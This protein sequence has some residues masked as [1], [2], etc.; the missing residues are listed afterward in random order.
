MATVIQMRRGTASEWTAANPLLAQGEIGTELDTHKWK[1][2]DGVLRWA[3]L[4]YVTGGPGP[5]GPKGDPGAAGPAG[6]TGPAG[7]K[8]DTG[9]TGPQGVPGA[10]GGAGP[11]GPQGNAGPVGATGPAGAQGVQGV[12]GD[13][14]DTGATGP[15]GLGV[16]AGGASGQVLAKKSAADN[17]TQ[18]VA[19][20]GGALTQKAARAYRV[21]AL[22]ASAAGS[23]KIPL[24][25]LSYDTDGSM[26][27][28][29]NG[30][31]VARVAGYYVVH[32]SIGWGITTAANFTTF[33][34]IFKNG[35]EVTR[36]TSFSI[37][38]DNINLR[39]QEVADT[40]Y[41]NVGDYIELYGYSQLT[42]SLYAGGSVN[43]WF[44]FASMVLAGG[45]P[46]PAGPAGGNATVPIDKWHVVGAA[47]EPAFQNGWTAVA[48]ETPP[49]FRKDPL[50]VVSLRGTMRGGAANT[51]AFTLPAGYR[52]PVAR[53]RN[54]V[55]DSNNGGAVSGVTGLNV[56]PDGSVLANAINNSDLL[57]V[58][59][60]EI[61]FDTGTVTA[62]PTGP[63][64]PQGPQGIP[65][66]IGNTAA[67]LNRGAAFSVPGGVA[68]KI[69]LNL[70]TYDAGG[71]AQ[72]ANG[73]YVCPAAGYYKVDGSVSGSMGTGGSGP[74]EIYASVYQNGARV[75]TG[76]IVTVPY[77]SGGDIGETVA[78]VVKCNA[79]DYLELYVYQTG[80]PVALYVSPIMNY[81]AVVKVDQA[82]P[83]GDKGDSGGVANLAARAYRGAALTLAAGSY[84]KV[85]ADT[86]SRDSGGHIANG[87]YNVTAAGWYQ[88]NGE[89]LLATGLVGGNI[90]FVAY[91]YLNGASCSAGEQVGQTAGNG[92]VSSVVSDAI[93]CV[94]GDYIE[95][96]AYSS[97][98][99][100]LAVSATSN[101]LSVASVDQAGPKGDKGDP[102]PA[103]SG[104]GGGAAGFTAFAYLAANADLAASTWTTLPVDTVD[105]GH[106][107]GHCMNLAQHAYVCP[108]AGWYDVDAQYGLVGVAQFRRGLDQRMEH[109]LQVERR[110]ADHL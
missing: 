30:R 81:L 25:T 87:R 75:S 66:G 77:A 62:M 82:G 105:A 108:A 8:G 5:Q 90:T 46:G 88:I 83:K 23:T 47:G 104:G 16:P 11:Q 10:A 21:G 94:P 93:Y 96:W 109:G 71:N 101:Y 72:V 37:T 6:A 55:A 69:P 98:A 33:P 97:A 58:S 103:G 28:L 53:A 14:G 24:D 42:Y 50:G 65:G 52:P 79:G 29:A 4:P 68:T 99:Y 61:E 92:Y 35:A 85:P 38:G 76:A 31:L 74:V 2:G 13:K 18:W 102:G 43:S 17:D 40:I 106:D 80:P 100:G 36:G 44:T 60:D 54:V 27:D 26:V 56:S 67:R 95:L 32:G 49:A 63:Q 57:Y 1:C 70:A 78:D 84:T 7:A 22:T 45:P 12:K 91:L 34:S 73:R 39:V 3:A 19:Q 15:A 48:G 107:P 64:G 86:I 20:T 59:L 89:V 41:L 51:A 9:A 110:P